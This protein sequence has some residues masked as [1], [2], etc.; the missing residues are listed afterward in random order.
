MLIE[1]FKNYHKKF[2]GE[3]DHFVVRLRVA[4]KKL[5]LTSYFA[6]NRNYE[7]YERENWKNIILEGLDYRTES[8]SE[9]DKLFKM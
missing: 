5:L 6:K 8:T 3:G 2:Y 7:K 9:I 1:E 4:F